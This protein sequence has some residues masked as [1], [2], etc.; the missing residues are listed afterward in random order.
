MRD[1]H[2]TVASVGFYRSQKSGVRN[3]ELRSFQMSTAIVYINGVL[4][5]E[6]C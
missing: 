3:G 2:I 5:E 6:K 1:F 4:E